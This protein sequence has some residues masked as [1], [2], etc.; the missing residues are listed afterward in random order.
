MKSNIKE[1]LSDKIESVLERLELVLRHQKRVEQDCELLGKKLIQRGEITLGLSLIKE[2]RRHDLSKLEGIEFEGLTQTSNKEL[3]KLAIEQ[4][5]STNK[6]HV[7]YWGDIQSMPP[8]YLAELVCDLHCRSTEFGTDLREYLK[9][10]FFPKHGITNG[11]K[12]GKLIRE[13]VELLLDKPFSKA[14]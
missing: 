9:E 7:T 10:D 5:R 11:C 2:G 8:L 14:I 13:Y 6:H 1:E 12:V 4:H 3:L